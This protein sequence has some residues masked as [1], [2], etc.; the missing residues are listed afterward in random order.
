MTPIIPLIKSYKEPEENK[1]SYMGQQNW[2]PQ[3]TLHQNTRKR[4][5]YSA[6]DWQKRN[7]FKKES[8]LPKTE[9]LEKRTNEQNKRAVGSSKY[10][11][12]IQKKTNNHYFK[13][14]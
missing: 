7:C 1:E 8:L 10:G 4:T 6:R 14:I 3:K 9:I 2:K 11:K 12:K 5:T 13:H